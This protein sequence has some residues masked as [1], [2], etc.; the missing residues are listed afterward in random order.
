[1]RPIPSPDPRNPPPCPHHAL[2]ATRRAAAGLTRLEFA[3]AVIV[4]GVMASLALE[5]IAELQQSTNDVRVE[6]K[7]AQQRAVA[8]Q[9]EARETLF[10]SAAASAPRLVTPAQALRP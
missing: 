8:A 7:A 1:M 3:F 4:A 6:T 5:R 9:A 10:P 2:R